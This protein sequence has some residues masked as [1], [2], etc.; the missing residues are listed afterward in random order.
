VAVCN[1]YAQ[2][3]AGC[4]DW[5]RVAAVYALLDNRMVEDEWVRFKYPDIAFCIYRDKGPNP[6]ESTS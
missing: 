4:G 5:P 3:L 1:R 2:A 6:T